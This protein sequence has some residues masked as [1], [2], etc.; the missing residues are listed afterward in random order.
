MSV[1]AASSRCAAIFLPLAMILSSALT[2]AVPPTDERARAVGAHA[3]RHAAGVAVDDVDV[4]DRD[5]EPRRD[6]L[7]ERRLVALAVAVRAGEHRHAAGRMH[8]HFA[9]LEQSRARAER[10]GDVRRRDAA[11]LDVRRVAD[12][13]AACRASPPRPC[14]PGSPRRRPSSSPR[15][16]SRRS[17]RCRRA[18]R[19]ASGTGSVRMKLRRRISS[20]AMPSST[21][22][23][24]HEPLDD[25]GR[26]GPPGAAIGVDRRGVGERRGHFGSR[27]P[28]SCTG[29]RAASRRGSSGCTRRTS[30][31]TRPSPPSCARACARNLPSLSSASS[32]CVTWSRPCASDEEALAALG[33]PLDRA[34]DALRRPHHRRLFGVEVDLRAEAAADVGRDHA[35]LVLGQAEHERRHQQPLDVRV[36]VRDVERVAV[37]GAAVRR[38]RGAR[39][40][41]VRDQP[42]VDDVE[43]RDVRGLGERGVDRRLVAERPR[44][45]LVAR[46]AVVDLRRARLQRVDAVDD[47]GQHV[48][49]DVDQLGGVLRL[50]GRLGDR[51]AR[52]GRRR[53]APCPARAPD[54]AARSSAC[55][56]C[57]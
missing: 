1:S 55:R 42:V 14:A 6:D 31:G 34:V 21:R 26:L 37:V 25:V 49:V 54:A 48:V 30:T 4:L 16:A 8:A 43:L 9:R 57:R 20:C 41:R 2:I 19:P 56:R 44:V 51:P 10:A 50:V 45:A 11:G 12:A 17:R 32:A 13:R 27:S 5:A 47:R 52:P 38:D 22:R 28:A 53:S 33:R 3:E 7:R 15:R 29:R 18:A 36:L 46:R 24:V 40:D 35:H 39:L 23:L